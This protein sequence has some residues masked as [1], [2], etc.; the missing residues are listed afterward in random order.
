M[1]SPLTNQYRQYSGAV[2][3]N[4]GDYSEIMNRYRELLNNSGM[5]GGGFGG[6]SGKPRPQFTP[7]MM[8]KPEQFN[9]APTQGHTD[10][11][12]KM[13]ELTETGGYSGDDIANLRARAISPIRSV[14]AG[15][16]RDMNRN[17]SIQGG[18]GVNFNAAK[19]KNAREMS[20][21]I[22]GAMTNVNAGIAQNVASNKLGIAPQ[23]ERA[24]GGESALR[25]QYGKANVDAVNSV[26]ERNTGMTNDANKFNIELTGK[27]NNEDDDS[28]LKALQGMTGLYGTTPAMSSLFGSQALSHAGME[29]Q[30]KM[31]GN[32]DVMRMIQQLM[33]RR[34]N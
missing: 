8:P 30:N 17:R 7:Q 3:Q 19:S 24:A 14:Y 13:K 26:N 33:T 16:N 10:A 29:S 9:Y 27:Y 1:A 25:N 15:A 23:Y 31:S 6:S 20:E 2:A 18:M 21:Q 4:T 11:L 12:G 32:Q 34:N 22:S 5:S 28:R